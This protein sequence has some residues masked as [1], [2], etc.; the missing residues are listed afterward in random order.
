MYN[1]KAVD[2]RD[3]R[4]NLR[5]PRLNKRTHYRSLLLLEEQL[6]VRRGGIEKTPLHLKLE[7]G[8]CVAARNLLDN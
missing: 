1:S 3:T 2:L 8:R 5:I 6:Q 4:K 7:Q